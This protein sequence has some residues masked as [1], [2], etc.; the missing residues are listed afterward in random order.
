[1]E[2]LINHFYI[3]LLL[4]AICLTLPLNAQVV[5]EEPPKPSL[6]VPQN[7]EIHIN[8]N[9]SLFQGFSL[10][11]DLL[12][13]VLALMNDYGDLSA[14]LQLNLRNR[15]FPVVE[16]GYGSC[17]TKDVN[18]EIAY[19]TSA[20]FA[21][22]GFD[23]NLLRDR[24]QPNK[25]LLGFRYGISDYRFDISGPSMIDPIWGTSAPY[26]Y[27]DISALSHWAEVVIGVQ[28]R[29]WKSFH[30]GWTVR[31]KYEISTT[32]NKYSR[33]FYIPGYGTTTDTSAWSGTYSL[34]FDLNWGLKKNQ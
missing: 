21:R 3:L 15:Y 32:N 10:S 18:T 30:M 29:I 5:D 16:L 17:D 24:T 22:I 7:D 26:A 2:K 6:Y 19:K 13:P 11:A 25:F 4:L 12:G 34:I 28:V 9:P 1:M 8:Q 14:S 33:P 20:P 27:S 23:Y 31:Y